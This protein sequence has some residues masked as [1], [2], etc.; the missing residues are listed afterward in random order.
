[1]STFTP[2]T[3]SSTITA[4]VQTKSSVSLGAYAKSGSGWLY[5]QSP[6]TYDGTT[7]S[8]TNLPIS[9]DAIGVLPTW[10]VQTKS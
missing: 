2:T 7:E 5:D 4:T 6:L 10:T 1:M 9:Y 3:K 8:I